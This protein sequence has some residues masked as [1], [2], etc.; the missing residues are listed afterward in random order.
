[1]PYCWHDMAYQHT[2]IV[3]TV[4]YIKQNQ[5]TWIWLVFVCFLWATSAST[6]K[7]SNKC[8]LQSNNSTSIK[9]TLKCTVII[10]L[11]SKL[12]H[13]TTNTRQASAI[14]WHLAALEQKGWTPL[15][16]GALGLI[17]MV[18]S[19]AS[20]IMP[21][22]SSMALKISSSFLTY[23]CRVCIF[24]AI[25]GP[26]DSASQP[27]WLDVNI[28]WNISIQISSWSRSKLERRARST[29]FLMKQESQAQRQTWK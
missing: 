25:L 8:F 3:F 1:M 9:P 2:Y 20:V 21:S 13:Q 17:K 29:W 26:V 28:A 10:L 14:T 24:W 5:S 4:L 15:W 16:L 22:P 12:A 27:D 6:Q 18:C 7:C 23:L 11:P 19:L